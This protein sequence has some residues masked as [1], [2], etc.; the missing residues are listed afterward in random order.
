MNFIEA[1]ELKKSHRFEFEYLKRANFLIVLER[2]ELTRDSYLDA[3]RVKLDVEKVSGACGW[4]YGG[5]FNDSVGAI[6][7]YRRKGR[8]KRPE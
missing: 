1:N 4:I 5:Q 8:G 3:G 2:T 6:G 7:G